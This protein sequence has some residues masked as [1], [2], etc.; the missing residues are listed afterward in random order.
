MRRILKPF[1]WVSWVLLFK[2]RTEYD[3]QPIEVGKSEM[4]EVFARFGPPK[5]LAVTG[6]ADGTRSECVWG[7]PFMVFVSVEF[8][9]C[10]FVTRK[11]MKS[12]R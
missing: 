1:G 7:I 8:D 2:Q 4:S 6:D 9:E 10:G 5:S 12:Y 11:Y 3:I